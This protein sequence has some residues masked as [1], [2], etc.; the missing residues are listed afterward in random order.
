[1]CLQNRLWDFKT[2]KKKH[3]F[4]LMSLVCLFTSFVFLSQDNVYWFTNL[5]LLFILIISFL[6]SDALAN[7]IFKQSFFKSRLKKASKHELRSEDD[8][9]LFGIGFLQTTYFLFITNFINLEPLYL[10]QFSICIFLVTLLFFLTRGKAKIS[11]S[12]NWR[13]FSTFIGFLLF[14]V[15][16]L[17]LSIDILSSSIENFLQWLGIPMAHSIW[18]F[19][20]FLI[21]FFVFLIIT[22]TDP[23]FDARY[24]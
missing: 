16:I 18:I 13:H 20:L 23:Y 12:N 15:D 8:V 24:G 2:T 9:L 6:V 22:V 4:F 7:F 17:Q 5:F 3:I 14:I 10:D 21:S 11:D 1:M 19:F